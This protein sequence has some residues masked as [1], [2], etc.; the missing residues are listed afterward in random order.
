MAKRSEFRGV[1]PIGDTDT[2]ELPIR[3][4]GPA[5]AYYTRILG[6][7]LLSKSD[8]RALLA[9]DQARIGLAV[10]GRD[11]EQASCYFEVSD[12]EALRTELLAL[13]IEPSELREEQYGGKRQR[14]FLAQ[15]PF[16][17]CFCFGQTLS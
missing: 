9:R 17:V 5:V 6:F 14:I 15:E 3:K 7:S 13:G 12:I 11:P 2:N 1:Y 10:N 8:D 16:G 4:V